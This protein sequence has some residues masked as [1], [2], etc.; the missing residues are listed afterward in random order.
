MSIKGLY[1]L[2]NNIILTAA[3][4]GITIEGVP[5]GGTVILDR[6]QHRQRQ[7]RL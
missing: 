3:N 2:S 6:A 7:L 5:N 1:D 4:S